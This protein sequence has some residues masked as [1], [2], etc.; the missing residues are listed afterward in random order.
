MSSSDNK[1]DSDIAVVVLGSILFALLLL[2]L[3]TE[4]L[5]NDFV[6][7]AWMIPVFPIISFGLILLFGIYD[8][9]RGGSI[10]LVGVGFSS[11]FSM[12]V[13]YEVLFQDSL[14]G[15]FIEST[16]TWFG[17]ETYSFEFGTYIDSLAAILLLVV[18]FVSYLVVLFSTSYMH[19]E[20]DRQV[21]YFG[22]ICLF[23]GVM[24]GLVIANSFLLMFIFWELVGVCSYLLI[25]F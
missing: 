15:G 4:Q 17:G 22:E 11:V 10:A 5:S 12:A 6:S 13:V 2:Y 1:S 7:V 25:G 19:E 20:G 21:R 3:F 18:G 14:H 23:V 24:L 16:R 8:P 9:R